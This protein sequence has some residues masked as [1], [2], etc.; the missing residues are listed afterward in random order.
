MDHGAGGC[1]DAAWWDVRPGSLG[2]SEALGGRGGLEALMCAVC[3]LIETLRRDLWDWCM[4]FQCRSGHLMSGDA[5][6][7]N[8]F[9]CYLGYM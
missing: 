7:A 9:S 4:C 2:A 3:D 5:I 6:S 1:V 8:S